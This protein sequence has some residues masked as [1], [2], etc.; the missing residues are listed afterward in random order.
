MSRRALLGA[1]ALGAAA[2]TVG[3]P[4]ARAMSRSARTTLPPPSGSLVTRWDTDPWSRG[5]YSALPVGTTDAVRETIADALIGDRIVLA[6]EYTDPSFPSTVQ[7]ALRSG[8]RASRVLLDEDLGPRVIVIGAGIAGLSAA[9]DLVAAGASVIVLEARDRIGGRVHTNTSWGAPVEMGAAWIHALTAN[10]VVPLTQ[11]AGLSLVRCNYDNE[12]VRDTMTGKPSPAAY[13][14]D[15]QTSRLSDQLAD[16]WPPASTSVATWLRQHGLPGNRFTNWAVETSIV[17]EYGMSAS[18]LGSRAL[19]EGADFRGGDAFVAGGY[20]R[21]AD[22]LAQGLD[23]RL[24]SPVAS[25]D[26]TASGP[27]TVTLQS[28]KTLTADSAVVAVPLALV[29]ANSPR[30]TP[31]GPTVRSAIGRLRTGDLE[32]VVLRYDKQWWGPERVIGIVGGGVPGQSAESALRWTEFFNVTD[33][34]GTPAIV[35]FSG[36]TA[37]LR[38]P[39]TDAGCV[40]EAVAMLQAA[41]SPQ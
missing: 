30:I 17:Q 11:Q 5:A 19:S 25:V 3:A 41:Y 34:V 8:N 40:A 32:K 28:G 21:I 18:L 10:P 29:Q 9:H 20:D 2:L 16:A 27:L 15:D 22:V 24:N 39:A 14:A 1:G 38:R 26:A 4:P 31:L 36:G 37:A 12:I 33:V 35:G 13:R 6:G 7:G 23:V